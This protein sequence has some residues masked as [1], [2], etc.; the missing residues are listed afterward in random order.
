VQDNYTK[1]SRGTLRGLHYQVERPQGKLIRVV[2]GEAF[3]VAVDLRRSSPTFGQ[4]VGET[5]SA[6]NKRS[7]W[8]PPGFAH[9]FIVT[10]DSA[11]IVYR[12]TDYY[13]RR[14]ERTL[15][16]DDKDV[17]IDWPM[18]DFEQPGLSAKDAAG[19]LLKDAEVYA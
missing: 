19:T 12:C 3:D 2:V 4:W 1:S 10:G 11:E 5:L 14:H 15:R 7:I 18:P 6:A 17:A 16:W 13:S 8:I 9:G